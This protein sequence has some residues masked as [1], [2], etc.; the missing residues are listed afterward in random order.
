MDEEI[1]VDKSNSKKW[2]WII[3]IVI[4]LLVA[5][6]MFKNSDEKKDTD[7]NTNTPNQN[8]ESGNEIVD[9]DI[10]ESPDTGLDNIDSLLI[11]NEEL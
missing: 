1:T 2:L 3:T 5:F 7:T 11:S 8:T 10:G 9:L 4:V 6:Y